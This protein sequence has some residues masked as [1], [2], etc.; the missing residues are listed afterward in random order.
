MTFHPSY[1]YEEFIEGL[2]PI[3][4]ENGLRFAVEDGIFKRMAIKELCE[5]L[6]STDLANTADEV[7]ESMRK[8]EEG[9]LSEYERY[10]VKKR[11]VESN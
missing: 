1:S 6:K 10:I 3:P 9:V 2:R 4:T 5:T 11:A 7:L 8:I